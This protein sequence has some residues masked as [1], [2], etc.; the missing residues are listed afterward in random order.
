MGEL[1]QQFAGVFKLDAVWKPSVPLTAH[2]HTLYP[3]SPMLE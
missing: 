3:A 1:L 2:R